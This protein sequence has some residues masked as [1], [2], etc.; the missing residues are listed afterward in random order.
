[1]K[2][3]LFTVKVELPDILKQIQIDTINIDPNDVIIIKFNKDCTDYESL[4]YLYNLLDKTWFPN[5]KVLCIE[6]TL[7]VISVHKEQLKE[8]LTK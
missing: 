3:D 5:N 8:L 7:D 6:S 1:M 2:P 4:Q